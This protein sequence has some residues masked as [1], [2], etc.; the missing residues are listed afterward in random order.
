MEWI[1]PT[2]F[3]PEPSCPECGLDLDWEDCTNCADGFVGHECGDD[4]C[5]CLYPQDN[6]KCQYC[7]GESGW[8][9]CFHNK[10]GTWTGSELKAM[11]W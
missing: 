8:F 5:C 2:D 1:D 10:C 7:E 3:Q 6:V 11:E 9:R 4:T